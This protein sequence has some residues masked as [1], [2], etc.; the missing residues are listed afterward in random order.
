MYS[1][2][3]TDWQTSSQ[4]LTLI[5]TKVF[6]EEQQVPI[7]DEWDSLDE[8]ALHF[9]IKNGDENLGCARLISDLHKDREYFHI[10]RVAVLKPFRSQGVGHTL[11]EF[12]LA[13]CKR[14]VPQKPVYLH[15]QVGRKN[16]YKRLGFVAEG[17]Q[18]MDAGIPHITMYWQAPE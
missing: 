12:I 16:F 3:T 11:V 1:I 18:F 17:S 8:T 14:Q 5:R 15:A 13:H 2:I 10:G 4:Q 7:A 6:I 9:L